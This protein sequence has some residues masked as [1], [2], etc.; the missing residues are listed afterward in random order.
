VGT[1]LEI[2]MEKF[3]LS[4]L[5]PG[6]FERLVRALSFKLLGPGGTVYSAGPDGAR[7]FT[8]DGAIKGYEKKKWNGYLVLQAKFR[9]STQSG[10][11]VEW[12][13][14]QIEK[15]LRKYRESAGRLKVPQY[16]ILATNV[17]LSGADGRASKK[18][19]RVKK[20]G[21]SKILDVLSRWKAEL[22]TRDVD[23]WPADK[24][25]DLLVGA[26]EI[27]QTYA[28][29]VTPGDVLSKLLSDF[30]SSRPDF[31]EVISRSLKVQLHKDQY[32]RLKDAG[33]VTDEQIRTS[34]VFVDLPL[35]SVTGHRTRASTRTR[36]SKRRTGD[37]LDEPDPDVQYNV[38]SR[39]VDRATEKLDPETLLADEDE[40]SAS[41]R[42]PAR[43]R[44]VLMGGPGQGKSTASL[45]LVQLFRAAAVETD[46]ATRRD[47]NVRRL[48][49][50]ILNRAESEGVR[51]RIP[52]R[53]PIHV[54]LPRFADCISQARQKNE[55][56]P[57]L[58]A[59]IAAEI[60]VSCDQEIDRTDI[61][62]W[63]G[64]YP[65]ILVLDGLDE[66][67]PSG[68]RASVIDSISNFFT[69]VS[70]AN[71]DVFAVI[72]TRPQGYNK[73]L[74][75]KLWEHWRLAELEPEQA[76]NYAKAFGEARYP[77]DR[78]RRDE[79]HVLLTKASHQS[80][81]ARLMVSPLQV[82]ILHFIVDTGGGVPTA[83]WTLFN[84]YFEVLKRREK[85]KGGDTQK[86]LERNWQQI[87]PIHQ[88]AGLILQTDSEHAGG[89][90][91]RL[92]HSRFRK[93]LHR[94]LVAEGFKPDEVRTRGDLC[95]NTLSNC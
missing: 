31:K 11:P 55:S 82:T 35:Q 50:E 92:S 90:G 56:L 69:E 8:F 95:C 34:Q 77:D 15:E 51:R 52:L 86:I 30:Q 3:D 81:T 39:L 63:L 22:G 84:E 33:S 57:S 91:S 9:E 53:Y 17:H 47:H 38:V 36:P 79:V 94:Y 40:R 23:V 19:G 21:H 7:D 42:Q 73:D 75:E 61:R 46:P 76:L 1:G 59:Y 5:N 66:L 62:N 18:G 45:F 16:Y 4:R 49:P 80:A 14:R 12:L 32:V 25:I 43:N 68:E 74:D 48:V 70:H 78:Q 65:W 6:G 26:P 27:R 87:G 83:R 13:K 67:P 60:A 89:A 37:S 58:L 85:A 88:R 29:W 93:L 64:F 10:E 44:I 28:A 24:I 72:T 20:S 71:A 2:Q 41:E 54:S